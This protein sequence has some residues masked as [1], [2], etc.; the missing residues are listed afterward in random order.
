MFLNT[1][2]S[3]LKDK[4]AVQIWCKRDGGEVRGAKR[5]SKQGAYETCL[6][7]QRPFRIREHHDHSAH[8]VSASQTQAF[9]Y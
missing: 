4:K 1:A 8:I 3:L 5:R 6:L 2:Y 9:I 7:S